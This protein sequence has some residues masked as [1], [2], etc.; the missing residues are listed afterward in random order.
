MSQDHLDLARRID[1]LER[2]N[3]RIK[4]LGA[5]AAGAL[6]A[7]GLC[8]MAAPRLC[9]TVWAERFVLNDTGGKT[10]LTLDAY[11]QGDP[12]IVAQDAQGKTFA[13]LVLA[14][15]NPR[16]ELFDAAGKRTGTLGIEKPKPAAKEAA[17]GDSVALR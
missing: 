12:T 1:A 11:A 16:L 15:E 6:A 9:K 17:Q 13:K 7:V 3:R 14:H 4:R 5:I 8:S 10:R 2:E